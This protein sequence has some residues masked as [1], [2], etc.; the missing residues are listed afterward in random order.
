[1]Y[2]FLIPT[3]ACYMSYPSHSPWFDHHNSLFNVIWISNLKSNF[4]RNGSFYKIF[5]VL[6]H[7]SLTG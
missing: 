3:Q 7:S 6:V 2:A 4:F 1:L 5:E